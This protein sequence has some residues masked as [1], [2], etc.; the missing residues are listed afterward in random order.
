MKRWV[1]LGILLALTGCLKRV[2]VVTRERLDQG[3]TGNRGVLYGKVP[4][5]PSTAPRTREYVEW[6]IEIPTFEKAIK[7]P[8]WRRESS[9]KDLRGNRGYVTGGPAKRLPEKGIVQEAPKPKSAPLP[10]FRRPEEVKPPVPTPSYTS[11]TVQKGDTLG[12]ISSQLYGT[13]RRWKEIY[14]ANRETLKDPNRLRPGQV[15]RIPQGT[16]EAPVS[17]KGTLK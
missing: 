12:K 5:T 2:E 6:D 10:F 16:K 7:I 17:S 1:W 11:Y 4:T 14:E 9:D 8:E 13:S 3:L 15:L